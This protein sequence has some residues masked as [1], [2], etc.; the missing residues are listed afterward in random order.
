M[1]LYLSTHTSS[2]S[3]NASLRQ[4]F[5][6][7]LHWI[8]TA[9]T[10][11]IACH[12][13][14]HAVFSRLF[15]NDLTLAALA[16]NYLLAQRIMHA[17]GSTTHTVPPLPQTHTHPLWAAWDYVVDFFLSQIKNVCLD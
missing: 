2:L 12:V 3:G 8:L 13:L 17:A 6:G 16:R 9:I 10:D 7:E 11:A 4:S 14:D 15:R 5:K 1:S